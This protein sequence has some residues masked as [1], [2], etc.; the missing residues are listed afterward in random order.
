[1]AQLESFANLSKLQEDLCKKNFCVAQDM[2][3]TA[4][5]KASGLTVKT[6][7]KQKTQEGK[8]TASSGSTYFLYKNSNFTVK[9]ELASSS[10]VK[11]S[12]EY[13]PESKPH[14]KYK[15]EFETLGDNEKIALSLES[16]HQKCRYKAVLVDDITAKF[17]VVF[18]HSHVGGGFDVLFDLGPMRFT[19]YNA[20]FWYF[21]DNYRAVIKHESVNKTGYSLGNIVA[22]FYS[23]KRADVLLGGAVKFNYFDRNLYIELASQKKI[24]DT[25]LVKSKL[26]Q[27]G[28]LWLALRSKFTEKVTFVAGAKFNI[29]LKTSP[30][31]YG[32][33]VKFNQ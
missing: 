26:N 14:L 17:N 7:Y 30:F 25:T 3:L 32:F 11:S 10:L 28:Y 5:A 4:Y 22:S 19:T 8:G 15:A 31:E 2:A 9:Q 1:M 16:V 12:V 13:V 6:S 23:S 27:C 33:R 20:A 18:G 24:N 29:F 21:K